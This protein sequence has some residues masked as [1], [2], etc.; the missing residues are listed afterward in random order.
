MNSL[1]QIDKI[2]AQ[3]GMNSIRNDLSY[4]SKDTMTGAQ[5]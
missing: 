4:G 1:T 3:R 5:S 2:R